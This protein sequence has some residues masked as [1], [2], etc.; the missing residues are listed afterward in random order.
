MSKGDTLFQPLLKVAYFLQGHL[1]LVV[2]GA[3]AWCAARLLFPSYVETQILYAVISMVAVQ[4]INQFIRSKRT[5]EIFS[6]HPAMLQNSTAVIAHGIKHIEIFVC[7]CVFTKFHVA[8]GR[9]SPTGWVPFERTKYSGFWQAQPAG[10]TYSGEILSRTEPV[11]HS[12]VCI[13]SFI[14][15]FRASYFYARASMS[16][17]AHCNGRWV[18]CGVC[19]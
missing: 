19:R 6:H 13:P 4:V 16:I 10:F 18:N 1:P 2:I 3:V 9:N 5:T 14:S 11:A 15:A 8:V 12:T 17:D 7:D